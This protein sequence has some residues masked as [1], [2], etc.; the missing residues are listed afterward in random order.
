M[1]VVVVVVV[2]MMMMM[3]MMEE[4]I[5]KVMHDVCVF[6]LHVF[7]NEGPLSSNYHWQRGNGHV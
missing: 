5:G 6:E 7:V 2:M 3:M 1:M 4:Y